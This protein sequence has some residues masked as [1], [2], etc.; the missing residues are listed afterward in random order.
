MGTVPKPA[1]LASYALSGEDMPL[2]LLYVPVGVAVQHRWDRN[3]RIHDLPSV[4]SSIRTYGYRAPAIFDDA[5]NDG[6]GGIA[7]GNGRTT[8]LE[9]MKAAG[10]ALPLYMKE[11]DG[12]WYFPIVFGIASPSLALAEAFA[13]DDNN[14]GMGAIPPD[15]LKRIWKQDGYLQVLSDLQDQNSLPVTISQG[16][17]E[18]WLQEASPAPEPEKVEPGKVANDIKRTKPASAWIVLPVAAIPSLEDAIAATAL[19]HDRGAAMQQI[20][21]FYL[22]H[23]GA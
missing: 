22:S 2:K 16:Q 8:A 7:G 4:K 17:L 23:H 15:E 1:N 14:T 5:L 21:D 20:L 13:I 11:K 9:E 18:K 3:Y 12:E 6:E 10:E 19:Q